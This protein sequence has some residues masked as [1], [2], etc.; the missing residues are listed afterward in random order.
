M[1]VQIENKQVL[2]LFT[3]TYPYG[4]GETFIGNELQYLLTRFQKIVIFPLQAEGMAR[5]LPAGCEVADLFSGWQFSGFRTLTKHALL[6][7]RIY[8]SEFF[9]EK[10]KKSFFRLRKELRSHLLQ[11][12]ARSEKLGTYLQ[13]Q[14]SDPHIVY[15]SFW[16]N[17]WA[18][19]LSILKKKNMISNYFTRVHG[20]DLFHERR[21]EQILP[22]RNFQLRMVKK[23][24]AVSESSASYLKKNYPQYADKVFVSYLGVYDCGE[25]NWT[26]T[27]EYTI[28]S[29]SNII[30]IKRVELICSAL[31]HTKHKIHWFHFGDGV[32][33]NQLAEQVKK[34]PDGI[35]V[36]IAGRVTSAALM[37]FYRN[38]PVHLFVHASESEGGVPVAIQEA[39]SFGI[40][41]IAYAVG[42]VPEIVNEQTGVLI[43]MVNSS[44]EILATRIDDFLHSEKNS[45][46]FRKNIRVY[47]NRFFSAN[48]NYALFCDNLLKG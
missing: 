28:V 24:G 44:P 36:T 32:L 46:V 39:I 33:S 10:R 42:G 4:T 8:L 31:K 22:F 5:E 48:Q 12:I 16:F 26:H 47:W 25:N 2:F 21:K 17:D 6:F 40:P 30:P 13:N 45:P 35:K 41:V 43:P 37:D 20:Y 18:T 1:E 27:N 14:K 3:V 38:T 7:S 11:C 19:V 15:Y 29:C 23:I 9:L 34:L